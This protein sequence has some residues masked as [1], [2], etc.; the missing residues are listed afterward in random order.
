MMILLTTL[1][2]IAFGFLLM[3]L[4]AGLWAAFVTLAFTR[5]YWFSASVPL[6]ATIL[7]VLLHVAG[8]LWIDRRTEQRLAASQNALRRFHP[9]VLA[10]RISSSPNF[11]D[12][13]VQQ[14]AAVLFIDLS[15]FTGLSEELGPERTR[16]LLKGLHT[17]IEEVVT[18]RG[19]LVLTYMG[20]GAMIIFGLPEIQGD[21]ACRAVSTALALVKATHNWLGSLP[22]EMHAARLG[23]KV[24]AHY[25][26]VVISRLGTEAHQ[27]ITATGDSVNVASRLMAV[28]AQ[29]GALVAI[30]DD[31]WR[32][33][34]VAGPIWPD[35]LVSAPFEVGIR[36]RTHPVTVRFWHP[37]RRNF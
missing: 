19:G 2:R 9:T 27:H 8:R 1:R 23:V 25:G 5:G 33:A 36:G 3:A 31:L 22:A 4:V 12:R 29:H 20:D 14:H 16:D 32:A 26:P 30:S 11:L 21:D 17:L 10:D 13:P 24:G 15:G 28:A 6:A 37:D 7:P 18:E 35:A 34:S